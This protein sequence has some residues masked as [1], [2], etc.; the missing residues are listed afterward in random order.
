MEPE[1]IDV[2]RTLITA[3][4][5]ATKSDWLLLADYFERNKEKRLAKTIRAGIERQLKKW[6]YK[7]ATGEYPITLRFKQGTVIT[8]DNLVSKLDFIET[9]SNPAAYGLTRPPNGA[10]KIAPKFPF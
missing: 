8:M 3:T 2:Q 9:S 1:I 6:P 5:S 7:G 4:Y 10:S